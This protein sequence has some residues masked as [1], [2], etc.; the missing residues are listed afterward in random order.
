M[1]V[2]GIAVNISHILSNNIRAGELLPINITVIFNWVLFQNLYM[3]DRVINRIPRIV[4][5][6]NRDNDQS[7][8]PPYR[9]YFSSSNLTCFITKTVSY[10]SQDISNLLIIQH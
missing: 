3:E 8:C 7:F 2:S 1:R 4:S 5:D 6:I 10:I 9:F